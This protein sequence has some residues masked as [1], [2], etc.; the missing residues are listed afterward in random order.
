MIAQWQCDWWTLPLFMC[1][2]GISHKL[3]TLLSVTLLSCVFFLYSYRQAPN[4]IT[5][6]RNTT[7]AHH[8]ASRFSSS[9]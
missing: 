3:F 9:K 4:D 8:H 1:K 7:P 2:T 5:R 6:N